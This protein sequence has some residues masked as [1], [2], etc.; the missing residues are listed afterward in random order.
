M[1]LSIIIP[2]YNEEK[3]IQRDIEEAFRFLRQKKIKGEVIIV[4]DGCT[5]G[6]ISIVRRLKKRFPALSLNASNYKRGKGFGIFRGFRQAKGDYVMFVDAGLCV[7]FSFAVKGIKT[8]AG[9]YSL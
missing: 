8:T 1:Q 6:T 4:A 9:N 5:D 3:K 7:P 2:C